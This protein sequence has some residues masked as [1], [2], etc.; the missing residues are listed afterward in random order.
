VFVGFCVA[1]EDWKAFDSGDAFPVWTHIYYVYFVFFPNLNRV[2]YAFAVFVLCV[3]WSSLFGTK[4]TFLAST[5]NV[6]KCIPKA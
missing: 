2:I 3:S 4:K 1:D 5:L 6:K